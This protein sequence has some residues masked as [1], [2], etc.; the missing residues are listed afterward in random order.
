MTLQNFFQNIEHCTAY[1]AR[2]LAKSFFSDGKKVRNARLPMARSQTDQTYFRE[3]SI[4][5][6]GLGHLS[7]TSSSSHFF[8]KKTKKRVSDTGFKYCM[9]KTRRHQSVRHLEIF[10]QKPQRPTM[11]AERCFPAL[12]DD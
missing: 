1:S 6:Q 10:I 3:E 7:I 12:R 2:N 11:E 9:L 5:A 4:V 8:K